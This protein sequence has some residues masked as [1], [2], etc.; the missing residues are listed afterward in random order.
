MIYAGSD[1]AAFRTV[2]HVEY[3]GQALFAFFGEY[4]QLA[5]YYIRAFGL[6]YPQSFAEV[7]L[8]IL[9]QPARALNTNAH[10]PI[11]H[12]RTL[13]PHQVIECYHP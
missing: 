8:N 10:T 1:I 4:F 13:I 12:D 5:V 3:R 11:R 2:Q 6:V 9:F 7:E